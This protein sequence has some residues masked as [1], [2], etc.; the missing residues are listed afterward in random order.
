MARK[1]TVLARSTLRT[2]PVVVPTALTLLAYQAL[3]AVA[4]AAPGDAGTCAVSQLELRYTAEPGVAN[5][6]TITTDPITQA[7]VLHDE[8]GP[9]K[10]CTPD[11]QMAGD[12]RFGGI[13]RKVR[14]MLG[15]QDDSV[16]LSLATTHQSSIVF[17]GEG[18]DVLHGGPE[19]DDLRGGAGEDTLHGGGGFDKLRGDAGDDVLRGGIGNDRLNGGADEDDLR[20]DSDDDE[21][22]GGIGT[23]ELRGGDGIDELNGN[24]GNDDLNGGN[25]N[26]ELNGGTGDDELNGGNDTDSCNGG[27]GTDTTTNC[28]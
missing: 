23:D 9:I 11:P 19:R 8:A 5:E 17:G 16:T 28:E 15:D 12:V 25:G 26:D 22:T 27:P 20:G 18:D 13:I 1:G 2:L 21:L 7:M 4:E 10:G 6:L 14:V 3:P 24:S